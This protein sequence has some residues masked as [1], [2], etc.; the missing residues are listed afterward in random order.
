MWLSDLLKSLLRNLL[1]IHMRKQH[2][3][4]LGKPAAEIP[5]ARNVSK[6][7]KKKRKEKKEEKERREENSQVSQRGSLMSPF[8]WISL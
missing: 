8:V 1:L 5:R 2:I 3:L 4:V 7:Q 6:L